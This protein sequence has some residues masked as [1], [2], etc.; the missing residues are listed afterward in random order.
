MKKTLLLLALCAG[1]LLS[2]NAEDQLTAF[3]KPGDVNQLSI[4]L[5][6]AD[7]QYTA[8]QVTVTLPN[9]LTFA[10]NAEPVLSARK[11][12]TH[13]V[14]FNKTSDTTMKI[15]VFSY[16]EGATP[17]GNENFS[18]D[19]GE[20][21]TIPVVSVA[22]YFDDPSYALAKSDSKLLDEVEFVNS[23][24]VGVPMSVFAK[25]KVGD[26]DG[27]DNI[28]PN[29]ATYILKDQ[30]GERPSDFIEGAADADCNNNI[31]PNDAVEILKYLVR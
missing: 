11:A 6:N 21:L 28:T 2:A 23:G 16:G 13:Q 29:D 14:H 1:S 31:T 8:F 12:A 22:N 17:T 3:V 25:G 5:A 27:N 10:E 15:V 9:G 18:E 24:L 26:A 4:R 20:L 30:V 7:A 19:K